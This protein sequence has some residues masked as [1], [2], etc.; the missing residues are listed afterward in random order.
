MYISNAKLLVDNYNSE[1]DRLIDILGFKRTYKFRQN[2]DETF[3]SW[4]RGLT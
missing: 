3:I 4:I 1:I 2:K